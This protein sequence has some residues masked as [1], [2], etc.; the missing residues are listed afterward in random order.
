MRHRRVLLIVILLLALVALG[1]GLWWSYRNP[2]G[3]TSTPHPPI[4]PLAASDVTHIRVRHGNDL[5][6]IQRDDPQPPWHLTAPVDAPVDPPHLEAMLAL[7]GKPAERR[8]APNAI[9][10]GTTGLNS[11]ALVVQFNE[12]AP[13]DIGGRGP[14]RGSRY[15]RTPHDLLLANLPDLAGLHWS[16]THWISPALVPPNRHLEKLVLPHFTLDR[17]KRGDWRAQPRGQRSTAAVAATL[18]AWQRARA[19]TVVPTDESRQRV[20]RITLVFEHG[21]PRH[22]DIIE[23]DP[24]LILRDPA[25]GVDYHLAGNRIGPLLEIRHP[26]L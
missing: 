26:G 19:L 14:S 7:L 22:L 21:P 4:S 2:P 15:V 11:P 9:P 16:W 20:A 10:D 1:A 18:Q 8:Y 3:A 6:I 24:N 25:L 17:D 13:I 12:H 23:R 5:V